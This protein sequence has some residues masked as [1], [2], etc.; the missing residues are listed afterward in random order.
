[1]FNKI[2]YLVILCFAFSFIACNDDD[3]NNEEEVA[4]NVYEGCC[5]TDPVFGENV[6][7][8]DQSVGAIEVITIVTPNG[9]GFHDMLKIRNIELYPNHTVTIYNS[10]NLQ[11]FESTNY[12]T[13]ETVFP[14]YPQ[15][16]YEGAVNAPN[17]TYR[18]RI[19]VDDEQTFRLSGS[20]CMYTFPDSEPDFEGC[21]FDFFDPII[22]NPPN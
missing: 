10:E 18:Y 12:T 6:D 17:G 21:N 1:M 11:I 4:Q 15:D 22:F 3:N 8:L 14:G 19:V 9:D 7:N 16:E 13:I 2:K 20:F 5:S